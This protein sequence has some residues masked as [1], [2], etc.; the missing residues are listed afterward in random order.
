MSIN[1]V[2]EDLPLA[3]VLQFIHLGRRTGT[4]Y[5]WHG[6][7]ERA[8][9]GFHE[10]SRRKRGR[11]SLP[12]PQGEYTSAINPEKPFPVAPELPL[13]S[14]KHVPA[15]QEVLRVQGKEEVPVLGRE[16]TAA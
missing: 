10:S 16:E 1:G 2:L 8:E 13:L 9:I 5:M 6:E 4:L 15:L 14:A 3:D 12:R 11:I 7:K